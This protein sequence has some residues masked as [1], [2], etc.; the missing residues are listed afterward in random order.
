M[1]DHPK[2][3]KII[4]AG[5]SGSIA[6]RQFVRNTSGDVIIINDAATAQRVAERLTYRNGIVYLPIEY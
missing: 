3:F 6:R 2:R 1:H 5:G 4:K